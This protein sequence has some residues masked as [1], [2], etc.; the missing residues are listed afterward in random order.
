MIPFI[1]TV[2]MK[3]EYEKMATIAIA[4]ICTHEQPFATLQLLPEIGDNM[5]KKVRTYIFPEE[6]I[7]T[8]NEC[9]VHKIQRNSD[10]RNHH[11]HELDQKRLK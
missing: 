5:S 9:L 3:T 11:R 8:L 1:Y 2:N 7:D 6:D 4:H 10:L